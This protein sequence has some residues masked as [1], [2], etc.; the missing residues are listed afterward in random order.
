MCSKSESL[1]KSNLVQIGSTLP[2]FGGVYP[3][4]NERHT[5]PVIRRYGLLMGALMSAM[6]IGVGW[7][8]FMTYQ[9]L[10]DRVIPRCV[11]SQNDSFDRQLNS[12][13][14]PTC[15]DGWVAVHVTVSSVRFV[16]MHST[17]D[18]P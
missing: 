1:P 14:H 8:V 4:H 3:R 15:A 12:L 10:M 9:G 16:S 17:V 18:S 11:I 6:L 7:H 13:N 2:P 5:V